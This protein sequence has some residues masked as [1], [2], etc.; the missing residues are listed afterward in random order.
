MILVLTFD[1]PKPC[2]YYAVIFIFSFILI[3]VYTKRPYFSDK[4]SCFKYLVPGYL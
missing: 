3:L 4:R 2:C 1:W